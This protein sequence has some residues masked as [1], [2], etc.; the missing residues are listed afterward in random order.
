MSTSN[1]ID[2][3]LASDMQKEKEQYQT[4]TKTI[5]PLGEPFYSTY[6]FQGIIGA[7]SL[8]NPSIRNWYL[9]NSVSLTCERVF[10][11]GFSSPHLNIINSSWL[12]TP[13]FDKYI[14]PTRFIESHIHELICAMLDSGYYVNFD[15]IDDYY[16][17]GKSWYGKRHFCHDGLIYGY[18]LEKDT[19]HVYAYD[20]QWTYRG[21]EVPRESFERGRLSMTEHGIYGSLC[22]VKPY[23]AYVEFDINKV[24]E[25]IVGYLNSSLE[26]YP[27]S[28]EGAVNGIVVH[29]YIA[30]YVD[31]LYHGL[32]QYNKMDWRIFRVLWEHK[33]FML[34][35]I[36]K[37]EGMLKLAPDLSKQYEEIVRKS[38]EMRMMY[39]SHRKK[40]RDSVLPIIKSKLLEVNSCE[41][42]I[43]EEA[44]EVLHNRLSNES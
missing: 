26:M 23:D 24:Y 29:E 8:S 4:P 31:R 27:F 44:A 17:D 25:S 30:A 20:S 35:R 1:M 40:R 28:G 33:R 32:I 10:L 15:G 5:L 43:L 2:E 22:G 38:N 39:A 7:V 14:H 41:R 36:K 3:L 21:F 19:Y 11:Y 6:H 18:D 42:R 34:E 16:M 12:D 9:N 37:I 13:C